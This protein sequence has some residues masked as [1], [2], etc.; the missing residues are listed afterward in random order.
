MT[1]WLESINSLQMWLASKASYFSEKGVQVRL[2]AKQVLNAN[3]DIAGISLEAGQRVA[4]IQIWSSGEL[5]F[6]LHD[7]EK[8]KMGKLSTFRFTTP[9]S[10]VEIV[11]NCCEQFMMK[12]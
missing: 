11:T 12:A 1:A 10:L 7:F 8:S 4:L 9:E 3:N 2:Q 5:D 6:I